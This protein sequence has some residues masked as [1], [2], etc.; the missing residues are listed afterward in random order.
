MNVTGDGL[1]G[2]ILDHR[3]D[4]LH[5]CAR[6]IFS[7]QLLPALGIQIILSYGQADECANHGR[8]NHLHLSWMHAP[9]RFG[10][11][12]QWVMTFDVKH[13]PGSG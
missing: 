6:H 1:A 13:P 10:H 2:L 7:L 8:G 3:D 9:A 12:A 5:V 11:V 4:D